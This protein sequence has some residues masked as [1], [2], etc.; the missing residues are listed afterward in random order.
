MLVVVGLGLTAQPVGA[1]SEPPPRPYR[2]LFGGDDPTQRRL[3]E[4]DLTLFLDGAAD[5]GLVAPAVI[6]PLA[7][8]TELREF[9][10]LYA[11]GAELVYTRRGRRVLVDARGST[12]APYYSLFSDEA[13][14]LSYGAGANLT[15]TFGSTELSGFGSYLF[16]P[17]YSM[18]FD[19]TSGPG[20]S[21]PVFD[22]ASARNPNE[23]VSA[24]GA[25]T[26]HFSRRS[27]LSVAYSADST[28]FTEEA[29]SGRGQG[30]RVS[31]VF[32]VSRS[33]GLFGG[34]GYHRARYAQPTPTTTPTSTAATSWHDIDVGF[35]YVHRSASRRAAGLTASLGVSIVNDGLR[36]YPGWRATVHGARTFGVNWTVGADYSRTLEAYGGLQQPVWVDL[37]GATVASRFG[38]RVDLSCGAGYSSGENVSL[39]G[40]AYNTYSGTARVQ[41]ALS[42]LAAITADYIYYRY[43]YPAGF[44]LPAGMPHLLDRQRVQFGAR[45]WLPLVR[46]GRA[47]EP[48][49]IDQ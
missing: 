46:G 10:A 42:A 7:P 19:A 17:F 28:L 36:Q 15:Y 11:V 29:R 44:D 38:R 23:L 8:P 9:E 16:S 4:L 18:A 31:Q 47:S 30:V 35:G 21:A 3:H 43:D 14:E 26:R 27:S 39:R 5:N 40:R 34:Y 20:P 32:Q 33:T 1:Q 25:W 2:G 13:I 48:R 37:V 45:F 49:L 12:T 24:G 41:V 22:F 6:D